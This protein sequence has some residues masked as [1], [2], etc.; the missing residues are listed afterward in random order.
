[1]GK[2]NSEK[3]LSLREKQI[4]VLMMHG[5][6]REAA[7]LKLG[8]SFYTLRNR[9]RDMMLKYDAVN[10]THL[11]FRLLDRGEIYVDSPEPK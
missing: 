2:R 6:T 3:S 5:Y 7:A 4:A 10:T 8:I 11:V 1:M 9:I